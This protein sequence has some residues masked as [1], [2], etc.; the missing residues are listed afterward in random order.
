MAGDISGV[1]VKQFT[2]ELDIL[3]LTETSGALSGYLQ[4]I[5]LDTRVS[6]GTQ[7]RRI[8]IGG[9]HSGSHIILNL[10]PS[11]LGSGG[12]WSG[13]TAWG[14]LSVQIPQPN[15]QIAEVVFRRSSVA[16]VNQMVATF[17]NSAS[18]SKTIQDAYT[19]YAS[20]SSELARLQSERPGIV[21]SLSKARQELVRE[22]SQF[23]AAQAEEARRQDIYKQAQ[24]VADEASRTAQSVDD[25]RRA[26][27]LSTEAVHRNTDVVHAHSDVVRAESTRNRTQWQIDSLVRDLTRTDNRIAELKQII[28]ADKAVLSHH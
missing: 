10:N 13:S 15:G 21:S 4:T 9:T 26:V 6:G 5:R 22:Q 18:R 23:D 28:A 8:P 19:Q 16:E 27:A 20:A 12:Q 1:Y 25:S 11:F 7:N 3:N 2:N 24:A 17:L 14:G